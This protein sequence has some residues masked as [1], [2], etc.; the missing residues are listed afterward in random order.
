MKLIQITLH[1]DDREIFIMPIP[2]HLRQYA[3]KDQELPK[4][5]LVQLR[6]LLD[7]FD[8]IH[9]EDSHA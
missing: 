7:N 6:D 3:G 5:F 1:F 9:R 4:D 8:L 2:C